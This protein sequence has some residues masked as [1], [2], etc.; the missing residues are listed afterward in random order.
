MHFNTMPFI[1]VQGSIQ[2]EH[3]QKN[4][5]LSVVHQFPFITQAP[6]H[7]FDKNLNT[8]L[9]KEN[10]NTSLYIMVITSRKDTWKHLQE[11]SDLAQTPCSKSKFKAYSVSLST[12]QN[13]SIP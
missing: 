9:F 8:F 2:S 10:F 11:H 1:L 13:T 6:P 5:D 7:M 3:V 12:S 4:A